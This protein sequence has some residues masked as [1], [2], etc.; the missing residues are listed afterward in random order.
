MARSILRRHFSRECAESRWLD[1]LQHEVEAQIET[2][3]GFAGP[4]RQEQRIASLSLDV[5][6]R[7][8]QQLREA[9]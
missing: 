1:R 6:D 9:A 2:T 7:E 4:V 8:R 5:L 3:G